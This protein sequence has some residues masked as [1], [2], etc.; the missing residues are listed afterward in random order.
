MR[1]QSMTIV[2]VLIAPIVASAATRSTSGSPPAASR[3]VAGD[4]T[5]CLDTLHASDSVSAVVTMSVRARDAK[6]T[7]PPDFEGLLVQEISSR[8][9]APRSLL[10]GVIAGW[11]QCDATGHHGCKGAAMTFGSSAYA[12]AHPTGELSRI[13]V[14][15]L[16]LTP[17]FAD[18]V[19]AV[20]EKIGKEKM[21]PPFY[22]GRDSIP[23]RISIGVQQYPDTIQ[24]HRPLF[25]ISI[26][27]Y[28]LPFTFAEWPK[29]AKPPK[30]PSV[31]ESRGVG[32]TV[33]VTFTIL[34]DG[35]VDPQ[36]IDVQAGH[37]SDFVQSVFDHLATVRYLPAHLGGCS[38]AMRGGQSFGFNVPR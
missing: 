35:R 16:S 32:D 26:P 8:L 7:L 17:T 25:R 31:A 24:A 2:A 37:Y 4:T 20:L 1:T 11:D 29:N 38:V 30:Y 18:T 28:K 9:K 10:L 5:S 13:G 12:T 14:I 21:S 27:H 33:A 15:D 23:L 36:S 3:T 19:R 34:A 22:D 6:T